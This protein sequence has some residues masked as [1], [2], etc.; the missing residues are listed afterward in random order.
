MRSLLSKAINALR[1]DGY[2]KPREQFDVEAKYREGH[3]FHT[4][5]LVEGEDA[6]KIFAD[7]HVTKGNDLDVTDVSV[8][9]F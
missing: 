5:L 6:R 1:S 9:R 3:E 7:F 4:T 8:D 2:L